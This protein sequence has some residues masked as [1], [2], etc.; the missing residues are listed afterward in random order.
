MSN[1]LQYQTRETE[2]II[3]QNFNLQNQNKEL[4][5]KIELLDEEQRL[6]VKRTTFY[7]KMN[8]RLDDKLREL[9][10]RAQKSTKK[11]V[12]PKN[13]EISVKVAEEMELMQR[14]IVKLEEAY[15]SAKHELALT[16]A[17]LQRIKD[18]SN[19]IL[20]LQ[21]EGRTFLLNCMQ[22]A[23]EKF[24]EVK[25]IPV[26]SIPLGGLGSKDREQVLQI[27]L[28]KLNYGSPNR[29]SRS[30]VKSTAFPPIVQYGSARWKNP[31]SMT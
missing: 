13:L 2:T 4:K 26:E 6:L 9:E 16:H 27:L 19:N 23:K 28:D 30:K 11:E 7:Q 10:Q 17:E 20:N 8:K 12:T 24:A 3:R 22:E 31:N 1:E 21:D 29:S 5:R 25:K 18:A 15:E 14:H